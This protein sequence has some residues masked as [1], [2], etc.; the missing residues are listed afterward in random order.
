MQKKEKEFAV[1]ADEILGNLKNQL[2]IDG[3][4]GLS[5]VHRYDVQGVSEDVFKQGIPTILSEPM[6]DDV[7]YEDYPQKENESY[8]AIEYLPG[9]YD[10][11]ADACEQCFQLLTGEKM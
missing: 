10:Q 8:F 1:E 9:Q 11:R 6:V 7:Y 3:L 4:E 5:V 2:K